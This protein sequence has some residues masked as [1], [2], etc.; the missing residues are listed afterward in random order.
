MVRNRQREALTD[1]SLKL[2]QARQW[3]DVAEGAGELG[4]LSNGYLYRRTISIASMMNHSALEML[5][6]TRLRFERRATHGAL[7]CDDRE[8]S[9]ISN[10]MR[11]HLVGAEALV[12]RE[13]RITLTARLQ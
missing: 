6:R 7:I 13:T 8:S 12:R 1:V 4:R 11:F 9:G 3:V 10:S 2:S 5:F